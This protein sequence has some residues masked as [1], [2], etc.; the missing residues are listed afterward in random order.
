MSDRASLFGL[1]E[2]LIRKL[3]AFAG[4]GGG[5]GLVLGEEVFDG[6]EDD[7]DGG[8]E[9]DEGVGQGLRLAR[10]HVGRVHGAGGAL[11]GGDHALRDAGGKKGRGD[12][13]GGNVEQEPFHGLVAATIADQLRGRKCVLRKER[14]VFTEGCRGDGEFSVFSFQ[15]SC[16]DRAG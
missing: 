7:V 2:T 13:G 15:M 3:H 8:D 14:Q 9:G 10:G 1:S 5:D 16:G 6:P 11:R 12:T 4:R